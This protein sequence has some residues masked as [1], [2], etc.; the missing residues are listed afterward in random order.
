MFPH[1][2]RESRHRIGEEVQRAIAVVDQSH[3]DR[4]YGDGKEEP[5]EQKAEEGKAKNVEPHVLAEYRILHAKG[6]CVGKEK[7]LRPSLGGGESGEHR[8][9]ERRRKGDDSGGAA[10]HPADVRPFYVQ[11][12]RTG[13]SGAQLL[14]QPEVEVDDQEEEDSEA[15]E[16]GQLGADC[17]GENAGLPQLM[18]PLPLRV[19][20]GERIRQ[21]QERDKE[22]P[23]HEPDDPPA[24][25]RFGWKRILRQGNLPA[26]D[27][28]YAGN[29]AGG[30]LSVNRNS[31]NRPLVF[32]ISPAPQPNRYTDSGA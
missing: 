28:V 32:E 23:N 4:S 10:G 29:P 26:L 14:R 8:K 11:E 9:K 30:S 6:A 25:L 20:R 7:V 1:V 3:A 18:E 16:E 2:G 12:P 21:G 27:S 15:E 19:E 17:G 24:R 22:Q 13:P 5:V 31:C